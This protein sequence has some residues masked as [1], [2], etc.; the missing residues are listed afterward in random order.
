MLYILLVAAVIGCIGYIY[1]LK[2]EMRKV[3]SQIKQRLVA[4]E[5]RQISL[6][7]VNKELNTITSHVNA[8][9]AREQQTV[10]LHKREQQYFKDAISNISHDIRTPLTAIKGYQQLLAKS[11]L[12]EEQLHQL[13]VSAKHVTRLEQLLETFFEYSYLVT[14]ESTVQVGQ[15]NATA[16]LQEIV[17]GHLPSFEEKEM[18]VELAEV[19]VI[20]ETDEQLLLRIFQ[21]IIRNALNY[22]HNHLKIGLQHTDKHTTFSFTNGTK[23]CET[24]NAERLLERFQ[25]GDKSRKDSVGL[26]LAI[27]QLLTEK[28][29]GTV[30][31]EHSD[32]MFTIQIRFVHQ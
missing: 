19:N 22:G 12:N 31:V 6:Q 3:S 27:V 16:M 7:L 13:T 28:L 26:G 1:Y 29:G 24:P 18:T 10:I 15:V 30:T 17:V 9:L 4:K 8:L 14:Q 32:F 11:T 21:N 2:K 5:Q 23:I 20:F 25:T